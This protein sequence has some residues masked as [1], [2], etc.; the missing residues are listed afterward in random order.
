MHIQR[1]VFGAVLVVVAGSVARAEAP[2]GQAKKA[3]VAEL[4]ALAAAMGKY[5][6][7]GDEHKRLKAFEGTWNT[8]ATV[9]LPSGEAVPGVKGTTEFFFIMNGLFL[10]EE[11][12]GSWNG[13]PVSSHIVFGY[14]HAK[15]KY[16]WLFLSS[17]RSELNVKEGSADAAG[18]VFTLEGESFEPVSGTRGPE[19]VVYRIES[20]RR[21]VIEASRP[22]GGKDVKTMTVVFTRR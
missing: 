21:F 8:E 20:D 7:V 18:K 14:D 1:V 10:V 2:A 9:Y 4:Q 17:M 6:A 16:V 11:L 22:R 5:A 19:K 15:K 12:N 13:Q 3:K